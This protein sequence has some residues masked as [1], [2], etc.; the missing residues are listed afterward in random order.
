M[1]RGKKQDG[2]VRLGASQVK[3]NGDYA[4]P[5]AGDPF[6]LAGHGNPRGKIIVRV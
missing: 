2:G 1:Y 5:V 6:D 4:A 3:V